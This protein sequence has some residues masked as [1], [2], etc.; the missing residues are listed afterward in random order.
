MI[1]K[2]DYMLDGLVN[3]VAQV[4]ITI[5]CIVAAIL[6]VN[7]LDRNVFNKHRSNDND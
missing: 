2:G 3:G 5:F 4:G 6:I 1:N 7:Y